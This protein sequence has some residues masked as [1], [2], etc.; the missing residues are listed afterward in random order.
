M[1]EYEVVRERKKH[2]HLGE[3]T[4]WT[5][6]H[7]RIW[8]LAF[9]S[10][11]DE[12]I[13]DSMR[14]IDEELDRLRAPADQARE[15]RARLSHGLLS[16]WVHQVLQVD[17][18]LQLWKRKSPRNEKL[19]RRYYRMKFKREMPPLEDWPGGQ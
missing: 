17:H 12:L 2:L 16:T 10:R 15:S 5:P 13:K 19:L 11:I 3:P 14:F 18:V 1:G 8:D 7:L 4:E 6:D 9:L